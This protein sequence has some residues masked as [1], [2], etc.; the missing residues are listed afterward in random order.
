[1]GRIDLTAVW[2]RRHLPEQPRIDRE[3][4]A[5]MRGVFHHCPHDIADRLTVHDRTR[6]ERMGEIFRRGV[7]E[8]N[9]LRA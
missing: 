4:A 2:H 1:M 9:P 6:R 8:E 5:V 3:C 7:S